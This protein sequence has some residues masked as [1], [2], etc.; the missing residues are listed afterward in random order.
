MKT[1]LIKL[2]E[3]IAISGFV[4]M[5]SSCGSS[6]GG[7]LVTPIC[8]TTGA[9]DGA[10]YVT[11]NQP[12]ICSD[13]DGVYEFAIVNLTQSGNSL[14]VTISGH[15]YTG[16]ISGSSI[17]W[18]GSYPDTGGTTTERLSATVNIACNEITGSTTWSWSDGVDSCTGNATFAAIKL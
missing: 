7:G 13:S 17:S 9:W 15:S 18:S 2:A 11:T 3:M 1:N 6:D 5:L 8:D 12:L 14:T 4:L 16:T 10:S